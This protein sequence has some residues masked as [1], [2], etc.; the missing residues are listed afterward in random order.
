MVVGAAVCVERG[1]REQAGDVSLCG[2]NRHQQHMQQEV[3]E[4]LYTVS[5]P[6]CPPAT[7]DYSTT[8][9]PNICWPHSKRRQSDTDLL[10]RRLVKAVVRRQ[11]TLRCHGRGLGAFGTRFTNHG[12]EGLLSR[13]RTSVL[14]DANDCHRELSRRQSRQAATRRTACSNGSSSMHNG[15]ARR[16]ARFQPRAPDAGRGWLDGDD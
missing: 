6:P 15:S 14:S 2:C 8:I 10:Q 7:L 3:I 4:V 12:L 1:K 16:K 5:T 13:G 9:T 11:N